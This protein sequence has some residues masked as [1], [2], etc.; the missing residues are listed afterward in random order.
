MKM[1]RRSISNIAW[2]I[3]E[4]IAALDL[5]AELGFD[6]VE[7]APAKALGP[8]DA[9]ELGDVRRYRDG[10]AARGLSIPALQGIL[11][12]AD[13]V[14]LFA[15]DEARL[16][17]AQ[18]LD[19][20]AELAAELGAGACVFGAPKLRD[21]GDLDAG[22]AWA[23]AV[24]FF[25]DIAPRF[26]SR[27]T[28]LCFE[29]NPPMYDCRFVTTTEEAM[30]LVKAVGEPG[31]ALQLDFGTVF[32]N[33]ETAETVESAGRMACHCHVSEP[34]LVPLGAGEAKSSSVD[35]AMTGAAL[36]ASGYEGWISVE[37]RAVEDW[38][39]AMRRAS[40]FIENYYSS[41]SR[42]QDGVSTF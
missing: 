31:F 20:V 8:L 37:M 24:E 2:P 28:S 39:G 23:R 36:V 30:R 15:S 21:P 12:G 19:R 22:E 3:Q 5:A 17:L 27:G 42:G 4:D 11:F 33:G 16:R 10:L 38:R 9:V 26:A 29:A 40:A 1:E 35:H 18:R 41:T 7:L 34:G 14:H 6:G 25:A 32:A 13:D